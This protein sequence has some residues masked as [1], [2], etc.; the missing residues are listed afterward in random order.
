MDQSDMELDTFHRALDMFPNLERLELH[1]EG[2]PMLSPHFFEMAKAGSSRGLFVSAITNGSMFSSRN[3][4][5]L[6]DSGIQILFVS[7]ESARS[8]DFKR[9]RGGSLSRVK[10]GIRAL[11]DARNRRGQSTPN[12]GLS[13]TILKSTQEQLREIAD[14]YLEL[15]LDGGMSVH[16]LNTMPDYLQH[17]TDEMKS[18]TLTPAEHALSW[19]RYNRIVEDPAFKRTRIHFSDMVFGQIRTEGETP[20]GDRP[21]AT[22]REYRS[23][24]WLDDALYVN[25]HGIAT[26][27]ARIK[28]TETYGFGSVA[29]GDPAT[30]LNRRA[31][32]GL[33]IRAGEIA[34]ACK[35]CF[36]AE[37][38]GF[39]LQRVLDKRPTR[40][41]DAPTREGWESVSGQAAGV[42]PYDPVTI[43]EILDRCDGRLTTMEI[44]EQLAELSDASPGDTRERVLPMM[45]ELS[46]LKVIEFKREAP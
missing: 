21:A 10:R 27:C 42:L 23:C 33:Q 38:I 19:V 39:R 15:E 13:V 31:R 20:A 12:V 43:Q 22:T 11:L 30:I 26:G 37:S 45:G 7:T 44:I 1:G 25:R 2:E 24:P 28:D 17:Y 29:S 35:G 6:L 5:E 41:A 16:M 4:E 8:P 46:R 9:I 34:P 36:I 40:L 32:L 18:Q 14:L 3:I